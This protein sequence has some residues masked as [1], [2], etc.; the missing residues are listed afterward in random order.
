MRWWSTGCKRFVARV[1]THG[2]PASPECDRRRR[3]VTR[4]LAS[5]L[6]SPA[7][8]RPACPYGNMGLIQP[9]RGWAAAISLLRRV[10]L[11]PDAVARRVEGSPRED[12]SRGPQRGLH[13]LRLAVSLERSRAI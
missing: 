2:A 13:L 9:F 11:F 7:R 6:D 1:T 8:S 5:N 3:R 12:Q 10:P 4:C